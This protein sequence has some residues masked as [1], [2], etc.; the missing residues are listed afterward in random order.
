MSIFKDTFRTYVRDQ[1][2]L[3]EELI[4]LG[5]DPKFRDSKLGP[6]LSPHTFTLGK[7][8]RSREVTIDP[9]AFYSYTLNRNCVI[10]ATSLVDYVDDVGLDIGDLGQN[11]FQKLKGAALSQNFILQGGILSDFARNIQTTDDEGN[12]KSERKLRRINEVKG[13][14]N[15]ICSCAS[16]ESYIEKNDVILS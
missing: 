13:D 6:R 14:R 2:E 3:R 7:N 10:R 16:I 1:I 9:G 12:V 11:S 5:N 4:T 8:E 15:L